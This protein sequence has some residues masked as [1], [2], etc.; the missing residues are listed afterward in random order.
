M[1]IHFLRILFFGEGRVETLISNSSL[2]RKGWWRWCVR[3]R[4][5][6]LPRLWG[7]LQAWEHM[8]REHWPGGGAP[9][10]EQRACPGRVKWKGLAQLLGW[11]YGGSH[12][13]GVRAFFVVLA[14]WKLRQKKAMGL[15]WG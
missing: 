8:E 12:Q 3:V 6:G 7:G 5:K 15:V 9:R 1:A 2:R 14:S 4:R 13:P 11:G 10:G